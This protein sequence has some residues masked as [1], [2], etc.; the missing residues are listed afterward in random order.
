MSNGRWTVRYYALLLAALAGCVPRGVPSGANVGA[1][2]PAVS[3]TLRA[4]AA[5]IHV[6]ID[7][8]NNHV[9][10]RVAAGDRTLDLIL[11]TGAA[12]TSLDIGIARQIGLELG[13]PFR[14]RGVGTGSIEGAQVKKGSV[15]LA[16]TSITQPVRSALDLSRLPR[17]EGHRMDGILGFDFINRWVVAI[18]YV[19]QELRLYDPARFT[20]DG[21]GRPVPVSFADA[22][23]IVDADVVLTDGGMLRGRFIVDVGAS[24]ALAL[25]KPFVETN[26]LRSRVGTTLSRTAGGGVGG[27]TRADFGRVAALRI[28]DTELRGVVVQLFGDSAGVFSGNP[29]WIG[30][31]GGEVLRRFTVYLDYTRRRIILEPNAA[32]NEPFETDMSGVAF[33]ASAG[34]D[35]L[36]VDQV[37][38]SSPASEAG[39]VVGDTVVAV[40]GSPV[41]TRTISELR[42]RFRRAGETVDITVRRAGETRTVRIVTRRMF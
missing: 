34:F 28:G 5:P 41:T 2:S 26:R 16:G 9:Y 30:N 18:D 39:L 3:S 6:P 1:A 21:L 22:H 11:D 36:T 13:Q 4:P 10:V 7:I 29:N 37:L 25:T 42:K 33:V 23:P 35:T 27:L 14:A 8:A 17:R 15:T 32:A 19:G 31:I 40:D 20:Y 38:P 12:Q 24:L